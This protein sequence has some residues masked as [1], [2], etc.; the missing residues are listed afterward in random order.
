[1]LELSACTDALKFLQLEEVKEVYKCACRYNSDD[2]KRVN[3]PNVVENK[4]QQTDET[5][6]IEADIQ[7]EEKTNNSDK[8]TGAFVVFKDKVDK[9]VRYSTYHYV[10]AE[11]MDKFQVCKANAMKLASLPFPSGLAE[12][13]RETYNEYIASA[14]AYASYCSFDLANDFINKAQNYYDVVTKDNAES[15]ILCYSSM[16]AFMSILLLFITKMQLPCISID[17][18]SPLYDWFLG[19]DMSIL[20]VYASI[21][22]KRKVKFINDIT[23]AENTAYLLEVT[24]R[25]LL[26]IISAIVLIAAFKNGW[27]FD[28]AQTKLTYMLVG[29]VAGFSEM[30]VIALVNSISGKFGISD[31]DSNK[32][33]TSQEA[34]DRVQE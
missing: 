32:E 2:M 22:W 31:A 8:V 9:R 23:T 16:F 30:K 34:E 29:F 4:D 21:C 11:H 15:N 14:L 10:P 1:M 24:Y 13:K 7:E 27:F 28:G 3:S 17:T 19:I 20:G 25:L 12:Q 26:G 6:T 5:E 33:K 18:T